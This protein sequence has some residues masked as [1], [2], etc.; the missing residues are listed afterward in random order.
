MYFQHLLPSHVLDEWH[1]RWTPENLSWTLSNL[2]DESEETWVNLM[3]LAEQIWGNPEDWR[4]TYRVTHFPCMLQVFLRWHWYR[5][6]LQTSPRP[7]QCNWEYSAASLLH[8]SWRSAQAN[9][10]GT[11]PGGGQNYPIVKS[12]YQPTIGGSTPPH[13]MTNSRDFQQNVPNKT[14]PKYHE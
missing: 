5:H 13:L 14:Y 1:E 10:L 4:P 9:R 2:T 12:S 3:N 6:F 8:S 7:G 11:K